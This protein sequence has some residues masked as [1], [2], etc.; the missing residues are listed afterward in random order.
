MDYNNSDI[1][2]ARATPIGSAALAVI[3]ISG[4]QI[5]QDI[6][7]FFSIKNPRPRYAH[8]GTIKSPNTNETIDRCILIYFASP[9][10]YTGEEMVEISCH[11]GEVIV[12]EI[13]GEL[14]AF[15]YRL[16]YPGEFS[17]RAFKNKKIDLLQAESIAEKITSQTKQ[18]GV[19]LQNMEDGVTSKKMHLLRENIVTLLSVIEHELDF[20][21]AEITHLKHKSIIKQ[22][23]AMRLEIKNIIKLSRQIKQLDA[24]YRVMIVGYP[25]VGK[26]TLFNYIAGQDKA[27]ITP[28]KGTTRDILETKV[29][30]NNTPITLYDTAGY[31]NTKNKIE[32]LGIQK[33]LNL[34]QNMDAVLI[35][36]QQNPEAIKRELISKKYISNNQDCILVQNKC[37]NITVNEVYNKEQGL[38][39]ISAKNGIGINQILTK[40]CTT[41]CSQNNKG[42]YTNMIV[43]NKRQL[44]LLEDGVVVL[45][46]VLELLKDRASMDVVASELK[47]YINIMDE[48][49]GK[50]TS[51]EILNKI[52]KGFCVGK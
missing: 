45:S 16:A 41:L 27:L 49:L 19:L 13:I 32:L 11:G 47:T 40:L 52:F 25:N 4:K 2:I 31:R 18:Y 23:T 29:K 15:G 39:Q 50:F 17:Y 34:L 36:D 48:L 51:N 20:N 21:E 12:D 6:P 26:S 43:C 9:R 3:R 7:D 10:S 46:D 1:I 35:V 14:V 5:I 8:V 24:G 30:V 38:Y 44:K 42:S 33:S 37:D 22:L 28:I